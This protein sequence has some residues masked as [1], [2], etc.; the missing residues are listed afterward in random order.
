MGDTGGTRSQRCAVF[1]LRF[2]WL[3][4]ERATGA[5]AHKE[6]GD[7]AFSPLFLL[8]LIGAVKLLSAMVL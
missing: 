7:R 1:L 2:P 5:R 3:S 6:G 4:P 8:V